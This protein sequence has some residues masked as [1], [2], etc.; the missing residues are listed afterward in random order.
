MFNLD[1]GDDVDVSSPEKFHSQLQ[2]KL[3]EQADNQA[4][5]K[6]EALV[7]QGTKTKKQ[8]EK[9]A[10]HKRKRHWRASRF[11]RFIGSWLQHCILTVN[12]I[13]MSKSVKRS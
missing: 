10:R 7:K 1:L 9:E 8:L 11:K 13:Q 3:R 5:E 2:E 12:R 4:Q 6:L